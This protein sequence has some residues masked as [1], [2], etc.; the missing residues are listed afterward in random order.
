[1]AAAFA[2]LFVIAASVASAASEEPSPFDGVTDKEVI[3]NGLYELQQALEKNTDETVVNVAGVPLTPK[4]VEL[5][6]SKFTSKVE[7]VDLTSCVDLRN[8][9]FFISCLNPSNSRSLPRLPLA[10]GHLEAIVD[11]P[12]QPL[13][14]SQEA[15]FVR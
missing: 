1:M 8:H 10:L 7:E 6:N 14:Q 2:L 9:E 4:G 11:W 3:E 5:L 13:V 15:H 12:R